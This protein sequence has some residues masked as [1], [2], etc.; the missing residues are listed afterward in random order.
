ARRRGLRAR[1]PPVPAAD[2]A[3]GDPVPDGAAG[4]HPGRSGAAVGLEEPHQRDPARHADADSGHDPAAARGVAHPGRGP[5][6]GT[7]NGETQ[8]QAEVSIAAGRTPDDSSRLTTRYG[9]LCLTFHP[10]LR[11]SVEGATAELTEN[12]T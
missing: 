8:A 11:A 12:R 9:A 6:R 5:H 3:R 10:G 2:P 4:L 7:A 1:A